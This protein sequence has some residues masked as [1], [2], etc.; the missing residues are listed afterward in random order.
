MLWEWGN[1]NSYP[2]LAAVGRLQFEVMQFRLKDE[3]GVNVRLVPLPFQCSAW[4]E[5]DVRT[6]KTPSAARMVED[7]GGRPMVLFSSTWEKDYSA[8]NNPEHRLLDHA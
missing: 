1:R 8:R 6:F 7:R 2:F 5:G 4:L 3:Y